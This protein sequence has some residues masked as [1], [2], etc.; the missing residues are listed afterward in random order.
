MIRLGI[1]YVPLL[2]AA[3]LIM[4]QQ[5]GFAAEEGLELDLRAA[6]SWS[7]V[8]DMLCFGQVDAAHM[9]SPVPIASAMGLGGGAVPMSAISVLSINGT[10]V[11]VA[12]KLADKLR[13]AGHDFGFNNAETAGNALIGV[14]D[15]PLRIGVPFPFSMHSELLIY[16]LLSLIHI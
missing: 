16:W 6:P 1:G 2:D 12:N 15:A 10:V 8:R 7:A 13:A 9:L 3:P 11:G 4:A 14:A 5:M